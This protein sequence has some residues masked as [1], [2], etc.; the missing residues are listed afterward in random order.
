MAT[1]TGPTE[2]HGGRSLQKGDAEALPGP[3]PHNSRAAPISIAA[4][5]MGHASHATLLPG[6]WPD[7]RGLVPPGAL[8]SVRGLPANL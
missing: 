8:A 7:P 5:G 3:I 2:R 6:A 4:G 1:S